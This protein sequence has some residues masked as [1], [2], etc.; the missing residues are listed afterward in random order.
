M[1]ELIDIVWNRGK[2]VLLIEKEDNET[3]EQ[4][5]ARYIKEHGGI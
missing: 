4:A 1:T 5:L 2:K 3:K